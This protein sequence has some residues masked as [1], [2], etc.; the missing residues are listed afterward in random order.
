MGACI[1][2]ATKVDELPI[3]IKNVVI[4]CRAVLAGAYHI[5]S[6]I[7]DLDQRAEYNLSY[8][9]DQTK[10]AEMEFCASAMC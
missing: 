9:S 4:E 3:H 1:Y 5:L 7:G 10:T 6:C 2:V 8:S